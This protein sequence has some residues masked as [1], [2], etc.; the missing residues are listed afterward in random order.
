VNTLDSVLHA[1]VAGLCKNYCLIALYFLKLKVKQL[2]AR[3]R[4]RWDGNTKLYTSRISSEGL[5][6]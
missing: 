3:P 4:C 1:R 6:L 5:N 2:F